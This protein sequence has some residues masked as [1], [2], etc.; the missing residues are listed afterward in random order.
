MAAAHASDLADGTYLIRSAKS[1]WQT[2]DVAGGSKVSGANIQL[3]VL[4][5]SPAQTWMVSH[6]TDGFITLTCKGSGLVLDVSG[7]S[8]QSGTYVQQYSSNGSAA[9]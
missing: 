1:S 4:N 9:Q 5:A 2:L 6:D 8:A 7:G 3:Y